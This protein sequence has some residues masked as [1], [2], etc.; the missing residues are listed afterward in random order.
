V[1]VKVKKRKKKKVF[2]REETQRAVVG[3]F[4][5]AIII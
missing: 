1:K 4:V 2:G 3:L 5:L